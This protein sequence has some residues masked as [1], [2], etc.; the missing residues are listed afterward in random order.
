MELADYNITFADIKGKDNALAD[1][2]SR[3]KTLDIYKEPLGNPKTPAASNKQGHIMEIC[4]T[5]MHTIST[6]MLCI[7]V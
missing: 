5:N 4:A 6:T 7:I 1:A 3:V 2:I